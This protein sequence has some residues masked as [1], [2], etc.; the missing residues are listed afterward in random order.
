[1]NIKSTN[2]ADGFGPVSLT[3]FAANP[4]SS[5][6]FRVQHELLARMMDSIVFESY[7]SGSREELAER[8]LETAN[9]LT[10]LR[11]MV[12]THQVLESGLMHKVL[13]S[14]PRQRLAAEQFEREATSA[15]TALDK[16]LMTFGSP[17]QILAQMSDFSE[18]AGEVFSRFKER[19][20]A[21]ERDLFPVF[22]RMTAGAEV[23]YEREVDDVAGAA[24]I[25]D[26]LTA[27]APQPHVGGLDDSESAVT[28]VE[29][30]PV[31]DQMVDAQALAVES[32]A[33]DDSV[34]PAEISNPEPSADFTRI[35]LGLEL[36]EAPAAP[37][38]DSATP[39][40]GAPST[41]APLMAAEASDALVGAVALGA[42]GLS[43]IDIPELQ[44]VEVNSDSDHIEPDSAIAAE[45]T[46]AD[47][48]FT[49]LR[50][51]GE[52]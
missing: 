4:S 17:S 21:E 38:I 37:G 48:E 50:L 30:L 13:A 51:V 3:R 47:G 46:R 23:P 52:S 20:K 28:A 18:S 24:G 16:L 44:L 33:T 42:P 7:A 41:Q 34:K 22:D 1:M 27:S 25:R 40:S 8:A 10:A 26:T 31:P 43:A 39:S 14:D 2:L 5:H 49:G 35:Q 36:N 11:S 9:S 12:E 32:A 29:R 15:V 45:S 19:F 6:I